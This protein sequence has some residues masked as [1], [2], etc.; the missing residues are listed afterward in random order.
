MATSRT[1]D[2]MT[3][4]IDERAAQPSPCGRRS[5]AAPS[6]RPRASASA[7]VAQHRRE[8]ERDAVTSVSAA[9]NASTRRSMPGVAR[10]GSAAGTSRQSSG[11]SDHRQQRRR[12]RRRAPRGRRSRW[13]ADGSAARV[14]RPARCGRP[15]PGRRPSARASSRFARL[16]QTISSTQSAAPLSARTITRD[17]RDSSSRRPFTV[18]P[19]CSF[20]FGY[21]LRLCAASEVHLRA[22]AR[23][24]RAR[25]EPADAVELV[26]VAVLVV[27]GR[28]HERNPEL[29]LAARET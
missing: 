14:R 13:R 18:A 8:P 26:V 28:E 23:E 7:S 5:R 24:R 27:V 6:R 21:C 9:A 20:S 17:C 16:A 1:T 29:D 3:S 4:A 22:R 25:L 10:V 2:A 12:A 15:A 19:V 11:T